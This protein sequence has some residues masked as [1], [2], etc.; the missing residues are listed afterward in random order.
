MD[1]VLFNKTFP[2][3]LFLIFDAG[4]NILAALLTFALIRVTIS[5]AQEAAPYLPRPARFRQRLVLH[6][7]CND[8][9][10]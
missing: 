3:P 8:A 9:A 10:G 5:S 4:F 2:F 6:H 1:E 7:S